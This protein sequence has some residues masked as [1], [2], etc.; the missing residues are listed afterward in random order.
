MLN[1][2]INFNS[3]KELFSIIEI[4]LTRWKCEECYRYIKQ[5]YNLEDIR[6]RGYNA[7]RNIVAF[8]NAI[9][10]FSSVYMGMS[11]KLK[12]M[13]KKI[14]I[15]AKR[16]FG[17]PVF[18]NYAIAD[19]IFELLKKTRCGI[20]NFKGKLGKGIDDFQLSLFPV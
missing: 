17:I 2:L 3:Q 15:C 13:V 18:Y 11:L 16:F 1:K 12:L 9:A 14:Y 10:Y 5:S 19:G 6:V 7:I 20:I 4:Y 8:I